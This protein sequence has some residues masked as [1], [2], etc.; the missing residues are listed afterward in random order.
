MSL[1]A[2]S[3]KASRAGLKTLKYTFQAQRRRK[4]STHATPDV[5][6]SD[7]VIVGGGPAGL[8]LASALGMF[9][10]I[11]LD[12]HPTQQQI[13]SSSSVRRRSSIT[14]IEGG[15]LSKIKAWNP[16]LGTFSNRVVSLTNTSQT[17]LRGNITLGQHLHVV[18]DF[19]IDIGAWSYIDEG[20]TCA[21][22]NM[23][24]GVFCK[25]RCDYSPV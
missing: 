3:T 19:D 2:T 25:Q 14:L 8:A 5:I 4:F 15:D 7:I 1:T 21:V 22:D 9:P 16:A 17:F 13:G 12:K 23:Q 11:N 18:A 6:D 24:V 10:R 20:R